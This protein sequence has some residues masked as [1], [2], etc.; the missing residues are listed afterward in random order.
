MVKLNIIRIIALFLLVIPAYANDNELI[1]TRTGDSELYLA[2]T[3]DH[4]LNE[5]WD[6]EEE[7]A[8]QEAEYNRKGEVRAPAIIEI[9]KEAVSP[10]PEKQETYL[11][12]IAAPSGQ[13][14]SSVKEIPQT[15][16]SY[17]IW[18]ILAIISLIL[19]SFLAKKIISSLT[20]RPESINS[21]KNAT[22][23]VLEN[24][25]SAQPTGGLSNPALNSIR[26]MIDKSKLASQKNKQLAI[27]AYINAARAYE[28]LSTEN[29]KIIYNELAELHA[30]LSG[31]S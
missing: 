2:G 25:A 16:P 13:A 12:E 6:F 18:I 31:L 21:F 5:I 9:K 26:N 15:K 24:S 28:T 20:V 8:A 10:V 3:G 22:E 27:I 14:V 30:V 17:F 4:Q 11:K 29:K 19:I 7:A 1:I 23:N